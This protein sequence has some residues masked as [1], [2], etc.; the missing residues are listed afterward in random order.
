MATFSFFKVQ[1]VNILFQ[2]LPPDILF[3]SRCLAWL[4]WVCINE[5][6]L[7]QVVYMIIFYVQT[8]LKMDQGA[9][10]KESCLMLMI[11]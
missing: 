1:I 6:I 11:S 4:E 3:T 5:G 8:V 2:T 10:F 9:K 7:L